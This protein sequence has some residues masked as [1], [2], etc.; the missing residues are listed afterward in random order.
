MRYPTAYGSYEIDSLPS[1]PQVAHCHAF[2]VPVGLRGQK[3][4]HLL[5]KHQNEVLAKL[6]YDF[7]TCTVC[8]SNAAQKRVLARAGW[9]RLASFTSSKTGEEV[10]LWGWAVAK[11]A[12]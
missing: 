8:S 7:A 3:L 2:F 1:Q 5:K 4:A 10:E 11:V 9:A 12:A 6:H